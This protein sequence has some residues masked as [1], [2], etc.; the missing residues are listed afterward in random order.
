M[1]SAREAKE[2]VL[3]GGELG[4]EEALRLVGEDLEELRAAADEVRQ[5]IEFPVKIAFAAD[6]GT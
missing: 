5:L 1:P 6:F 2:K 3:G 4:R